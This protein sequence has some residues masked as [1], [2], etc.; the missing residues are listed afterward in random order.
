MYSLLFIYRLLGRRVLGLL[1]Y[2]LIAYF[3]LS[4]R[5]ARNASLDFLNRVYHY[6]RTVNVFT[7][8]PGLWHSFRHF[9][10]FGA[11]SLDRLAAWMGDI[12]RDKVRFDNLQQFLDGAGPGRGGIIIASHLGSIEMCRALVDGHGEVK[13][14]VLVHTHHAVQFNKLLKK[15]NPRVELN[16]IQVSTIGPDTAMLLHDKISNGEYVIIMGDR[17]AAARSGRVNYL[18]FLGKPAPFAQGPFILAGL[19]KCPVY[20]M[21]CL[22]RDGRY[23]VYFEPFAER[24][25][26]PRR[27]RQAA[28][29][30][31]IERYKN[32][33]EHYCVREPLQWFNFF[34]FWHSD[35]VAAPRALSA[36]KYSS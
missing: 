24:L 22:Q 18:E 28:L 35:D 4:S 17:T 8:R 13:M 9:M 6:D 1:L 3:F 11:S 27:D 5:R 34:D 7:T 21:F 15:V 36:N 20:L 32:R 12:R 26:L 2:P 30:E 14:N 31:H 23:R 16:L 19:M 33:L 25:A 29:Q 10:A